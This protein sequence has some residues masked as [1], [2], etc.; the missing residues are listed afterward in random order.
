ME[1]NKLRFSFLIIRI[2]LVTNLITLG[3]IDFLYCQEKENKEGDDEQEQVWNVSSAARYYSRYTR[4][5]VDLSEDRPAFSF[6]SE[7]GHECGLSAGFEA[8]ALTETNGG[9]EHSAFHL[10]YEYPLNTSISFT[11]TYTYYSYKTD[12]LSV[13][14]GIS[15]TILLGGTFK[16]SGFLLSVSYAAFFG[17]GTANYIATGT[18]ANYEIGHLRVVPSIQLCFASQTVSDS[19]LPKNRGKGKGN[20]KGTGST[21]TTTITGM[22]N[23]TICIAFRYHLGKDF[24]ISAMPSYVY[25]P[26]DL[27]VS[28]N[29]FIL[30]IGLEHSIDF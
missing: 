28:T 29:Q 4:Y 26:T 23:L 11:G 30:T 25:S 13:L 22:S 15:N 16:V 21:L 24:V 18:S 14:D 12:T 9:Y 6:E 3:T 17:G 8:F 27:A 20:K 2:A 10:G 19:L 7:I 5:G 1:K